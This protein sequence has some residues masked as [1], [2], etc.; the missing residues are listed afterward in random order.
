MPWQVSGLTLKILQ[1]FIAGTAV[2]CWSFTLVPWRVGDISHFLHSR[3]LV[4]ALAFPCSPWQG[5]LSSCL[6]WARWA[7]TLAVHE[8]LC[9]GHSEMDFTQLQILVGK[10]KLKDCSAL[11]TAR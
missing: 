6:G 7:V 2:V 11:F 3:G 1:S 8:A 9:A 10:V 5:S 4:P